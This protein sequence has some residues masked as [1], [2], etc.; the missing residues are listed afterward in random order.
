MTRIAFVCLHGSAK[1]LIAAHYLEQAAAERGLALTATTSGPEPDDAVLAP[2]IE[3]LRAR[4]IDVAGV[5]PARLSPATVA[6]AE[7]V[8]S[9]GYDLGSLMPAGAAIE[10]WDDCPAVSDG[11]DTAWAFITQRV[12]GLVARYSSGGRTR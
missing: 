6:G 2:V 12:D 4:G 1:S 10:R 7:L 5:T 9:F 11:F 3:G 8:V